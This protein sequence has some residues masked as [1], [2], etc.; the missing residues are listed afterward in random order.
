M[1]SEID[2]KQWLA[3]QMGLEDK[4]IHY[5]EVSSGFDHEVFESARADAL[6]RYDE[7]SAGV[8]TEHR[9]TGETKL[10]S[11]LR[12]VSA[13]LNGVLQTV[14]HAKAQGKDVDMDK[15]LDMVCLLRQMGSIN[16]NKRLENTAH[17]LEKM[18]PNLVHQAQKVMN[19]SKDS[20]TK[21]ACDI[22]M[23]GKQRH[24]EKIESA[25][26]FARA[27]EHVRDKGQKGFNSDQLVS[28]KQRTN[29][30][31]HGNNQH[32]D[33][34]VTPCQIQDAMDKNH[35]LKEEM[36]GKE[37]LLKHLENGIGFVRTNQDGKEVSE[38]ILQ[39]SI[40]NSR[41]YYITRERL[42]EAMAVPDEIALPVG[43]VIE[44]EEDRQISEGGPFEEARDV[45]RILANRALED[46][47]KEH[48][49]REKG[50]S[51]ERGIEERELEV[52]F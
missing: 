46:F 39:K 11:H 44:R 4:D 9:S 37:A 17:L 33:K 50:I 10:D 52:A 25:F 28:L 34:A 32:D 40:Q 13:D 6:A 5:F 38:T 21:Q 41:P 15:T 3:Q 23:N 30:L 19:I 27:G 8:D 7:I 22:I 24:P 20:L 18:R 45:D 43:Q 35:Y 14:R 12:E 26:L 31:M 51:H 36:Q 42:D 48:G 49:L 2:Q 29:R 16:D 47:G 1:M